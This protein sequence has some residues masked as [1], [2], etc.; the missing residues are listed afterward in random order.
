MENDSQL[1]FTHV[2]NINK[3]GL[4]IKDVLVI[5]KITKNI[6]SVSKLV[7]NN[8]ANLTLFFC[9]KDKMPGTLLAKGSN[10]QGLDQLE[11]NNLFV[12]T[13]SQDWKKSESICNLRLGHIILISLKF[14]NNNGCIDVRSWNKVSAICTSCRLEKSC[15]LYFKSRNKIEQFIYILFIVISGDQHLLSHHNA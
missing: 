9:K 6:L 7:K 15:K 8:S 4:N 3:L 12:L 11:D 5:P 2:G 10:T 14:L 1:K 13:I